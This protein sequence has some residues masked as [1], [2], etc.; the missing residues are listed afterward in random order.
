MHSSE[1]SRESRYVTGTEYF[2]TAVPCQYHRDV[3]AYCIEV[4]PVL[5]F[6]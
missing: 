3:P 6:S 5:L 4:K 2:S 1:Q